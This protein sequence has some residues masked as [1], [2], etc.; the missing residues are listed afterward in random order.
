[1]T[2]LDKFKVTKQN[3]HSHLRFTH[4]YTE[5]HQQLCIVKAAHTL[6]TT[7]EY[8]VVLKFANQDS[9]SV[10]DAQKTSWVV[11][12]YWRSWKD[13]EEAIVIHL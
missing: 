1:M 5:H 13:S 7:I 4:E 3:N 6:A 11:K 2:C 8:I 12:E 9:V 10:S